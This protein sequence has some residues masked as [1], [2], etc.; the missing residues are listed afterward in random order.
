MAY[1]DN[2]STSDLLKRADKDGVTILTLNAPKSI[3]ALSEAMLA[4]LSDAFDQIAADRS[5]K[6]VILRSAGQSFLRRSQ[7]QGNDRAPVGQGRRVSVFPGSF[8]HLLSHDV[9][10]GA[11]AATGDRRGQGHRNSRRMPAC[12]LLRSGCG[13]RG[14]DLC[15]LGR[16]Y[17]AFLF[18]TDGR[19]QPQ[20]AAQA[21]NGNA[22]CWG[23]SCRQPVSPRW[24]WS[25]ASSRLI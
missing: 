22:A 3:N 18:D 21:G 7:S 17:R 14:C 8:C 12:G 1:E 16:Q 6:A 11:P 20:C 10:R 2:T 24:G 23:N 25:T 15:H 19:A 9:A 13:L 5:I 4:A